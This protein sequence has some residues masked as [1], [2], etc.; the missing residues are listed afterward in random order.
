[1]FPHGIDVIVDAAGDDQ[2]MFES[3]V[4]LLAPK[5]RYV[6]YSFFY[7]EPKF[8]RV[9]PGLM[10]RKGLQIVGSTLSMFRFRDCLNAVDAKPLVM[11]TYPLERYFEALD[12]AMNDPDVWKVV[13]H[14][15]E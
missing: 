11:A 13:I 9:E 1:M 8:I 4:R 3:C 12:R 2:Q 6:L 7:Q 15:Q 14:P 5:G 10:I